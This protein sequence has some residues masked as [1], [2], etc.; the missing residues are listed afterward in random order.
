[1]VKDAEAGVICPSENPEAM[2]ECVR[3]LYTMPKSER[4]AFGERGRQTYLH[5]YTRKVQVSRVEKI[6]KQA[7]GNNQQKG[8]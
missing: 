4:E 7:A 5:N 6:L 1:V 3:R 8:S 2:A